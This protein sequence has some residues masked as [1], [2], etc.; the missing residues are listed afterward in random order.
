M[1]VNSDFLKTIK[2]K[3]YTDLCSLSLVDFAKVIVCVRTY[4][5]ISVAIRLYIPS[6][7]TLCED[8]GR[9]TK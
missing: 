9:A 4:S 5:E 6:K 7:R 3:N 1:F 8:Y 2:D